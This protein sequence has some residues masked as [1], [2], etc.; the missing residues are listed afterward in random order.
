MFV[1][2]A[3]QSDLLIIL[4]YVALFV[5]HVVSC[6][7]DVMWYLKQTQEVKNHR[8]GKTLGVVQTAAWS[9]CLLRPHF[10][11]VLTGN[12]D[13]IIARFFEQIKSNSGG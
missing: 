6:R 13:N 12:S 9:S 3:D 7:G 2:T 10:E 1:S 11:K 8:E 5:S 4:P